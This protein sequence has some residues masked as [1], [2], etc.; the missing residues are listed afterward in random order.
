MLITRAIDEAFHV[1]FM[2]LHRREPFTYGELM[3]FRFKVAP[4]DP[5]IKQMVE[6]EYT[7]LQARQ[8][9]HC[10]YNRFWPTIGKKKPKEEFQYPT[11]HTAQTHYSVEGGVPENGSQIIDQDEIN[12]LIESGVF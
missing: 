8:S 5:V 2:M 9:G 11:G 1:T 12:R 3:D 7:H 10:E 4:N 6:R